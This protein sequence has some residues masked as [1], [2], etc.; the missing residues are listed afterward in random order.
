M[1]NQPFKCSHCGGTELGGFR[2]DAVDEEGNDC[3]V[4]ICMDC[5]AKIAAKHGA[6]EKEK[7]LNERS[8]NNKQQQERSL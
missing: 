7:Q 4:D 8:H 6:S 3:V 2:F 5:L 1:Q